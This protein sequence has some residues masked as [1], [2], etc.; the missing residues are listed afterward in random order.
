[1]KLWDLRE[2]VSVAS[3]DHGGAKLTSI[4]FNENGYLCATA[5]SDHKLRVWDLRKLKTV[6][7]ME[8][9]GITSLGFDF[10]GTY[11]GYSSRKESSKN[12]YTMHACIVKEYDHDL[13][14]SAAAMEHAKE[15]SCFAWGYDAS[16]LLTASLDRHLKIH[17]FV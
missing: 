3:F 11:L 7:E 10:S 2:Q 4:S 1:M 12:L 9:E 17:H 8:V 15:I 16:F 14:A 13:F 6:K 5:A